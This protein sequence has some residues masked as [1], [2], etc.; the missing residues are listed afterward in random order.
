VIGDNIFAML[1]VE[2]YFQ[3]FT[4]K[5]I[6]DASKTTEVLIAISAASREQ[7]DELADKAL[8]AGGT[9]ANDT[10]DLGFMYTRSIS[11]LDGHIWEIAYMDMAAADGQA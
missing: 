9:A 11:D 1:L 3:T 8:A 10:Q 6:A 4:K 7:V 5:S 2:S